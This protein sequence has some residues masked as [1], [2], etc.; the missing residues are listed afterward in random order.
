VESVVKEL[1]SKMAEQVKLPAGYSIKFGGQ[2]ENLSKAK[3]RLAIAVPA[4]LLLILMMLYFAFGSLRYGILIFTAIPLSAIGGIIALTTRDMPFS[5]SAGIGFIALFGVAVLNGIVL[6]TEFNRLKKEGI[7][8]LNALIMEGTKLRL[9]PVLMTAA[10]AS[11]GFLPMALSQGSGAEV[12]RPLATV[13][14]GGLITATILTLVVLPVLYYWL[15][16]RSRRRLRPSAAVSVILVLLFSLPAVAVA[17]QAPQGSVH[18][19]PDI[20]GKRL[21]LTEMIDLAQRNN[22]SLAAARKNVDYTRSLQSTAFELPKTVIGGE[23]GK[24]NSTYNDNR[25]FVSQSIG[26]PVVY[27]RQKKLYEAETSLQEQ[28]VVVREQ[29]L[30]RQVRIRFYEFSV[31]LEKQKL[32]LELD[33]IYN[34]FANAADV[35]LRA[36]ETNM[37]EKT[38]ALSLVEQLA[39]QAA[40]LREDL[41]VYQEKLKLLLNTNEDVLPDYDNIRLNAIL[42]S[43]SVPQANPLFEY[44]QRQFESATAQT[45]V[46]RNRLSPDFTVG[47]NNLS[48]RGYQSKDGVNQQFYSGADRFSF[49]QLSVGIPLFAK[50]ARNRVRAMQVRE[51]A[52]KAESAAGSQ[53][54]SNELKVLSHEQQKLLLR[55]QYYEKTGLA[56]AQLIIKNAILGFKNGDIGYVEWTVLMNNAVSMRSGYLDAVSAFNNAVI[57]IQYLTGQ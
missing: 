19:D 16:N 53:Q 37:L 57:G 7:T 24:F 51:Q 2:F 1:Q 20:P 12:Q 45:A 48:I 32:L 40:E 41:S 27:Q 49:Y 38:T 8:D 50:A 31:L 39:L 11:L 36:G 6:I 4:A 33:S 21:S 14:I 56:H 3:S 29:E 5:I 47:Y 18:S 30:R 54:M 15:E 35:R 17:Q 55:L 25:F 44:Y 10:V 9:R 46:E 23:Y 26:L 28:A 34:D 52:V 43:D 22:L 13:V 42:V